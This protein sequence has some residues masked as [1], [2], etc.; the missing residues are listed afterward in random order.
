MAAAL[1]QGQSPS[2]WARSRAVSI[3][4][5][6]THLRRLKDKTGAGRLSDL[7]HRLNGA[8]RAV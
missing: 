5:A 2:T 4:T 8:W 3:N 1:V 6:Y 7:I